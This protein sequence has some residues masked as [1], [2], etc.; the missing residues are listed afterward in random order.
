[1]DVEMRNVVD[2]GW[3][4]PAR[5]PVEQHPLERDVGTPRNAVRKRDHVLLRVHALR[6][7]IDAAFVGAA[8]TAVHVRIHRQAIEGRR[9]KHDA[10]RDWR[11]RA[12]G[13]RIARD[14]AMAERQ[15]PAETASRLGLRVR[16]CAAA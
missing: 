4:V 13:L 12:V 9:G 2:A 1:M 15:L 6:L 3:D 14:R 11:T 8:V 5:I 10:D 7:R 16:R